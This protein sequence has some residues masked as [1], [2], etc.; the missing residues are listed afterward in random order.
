MQ[1]LLAW[2]NIIF[3]IALAASLLMVGGIILGVGV[4]SDADH[5]L[6]HDV[7]VDIDHSLEL[8]ADHDMDHDA[9]HDHEAKDGNPL[10]ASAGQSRSLFARFMSV[11]G[12]GKVPLTYLLLL[13]FLTFG[14]I[15]FVSNTLLEPLLVSPWIYFWISLTLAIF[16][17]I[18]FT[19][20]LAKLVNKYMPSTETYAP[21]KMD[22]IGARGEVAIKTTDEFGVAQV[23]DNRGNLHRINCTTEQ[24]EFL[25][26]HKIIVVE[27]NDKTDFFIVDADPVSALETN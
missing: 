16:G 24:G 2:Y 25:Q 7:D 22:L 6:E 10:D 27:Y 4:D 23:Y 15:G 5:D 14:G 18:F 13:L 26:G 1:E 3:Y 17:A 11:A 8:D 9:D 12:V 19:G 20:R 21:N